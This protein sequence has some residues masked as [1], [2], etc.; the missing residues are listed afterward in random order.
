MK[1]SMNVYQ[2]DIL[3]E[4]NGMLRRMYLAEAGN[5]VG[6]MPW[7]YKFDKVKIAGIAANSANKGE[8]VIMVPFDEQNKVEF[9]I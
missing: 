9:F 6:P 1:A 8:E 5:W 7:D 3:V 4:E 2:M